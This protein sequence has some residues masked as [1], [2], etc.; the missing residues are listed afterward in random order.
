M[1]NLPSLNK[2]EREK[3]EQTNYRGEQKFDHYLKKKKKG[4][5]LKTKS[6]WIIGGF[7]R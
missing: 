5:F 4:I 1:Y 2:E 3:Y 7:D 6:R